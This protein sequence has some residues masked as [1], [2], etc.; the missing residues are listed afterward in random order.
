[1]V[2]PYILHALPSQTILSFFLNGTINSAISF[3]S[4]WTIF[5]L[6]KTHNKQISLTTWL[7]G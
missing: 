6:A 4:L 5:W 1:M 7:A 2:A 3:R